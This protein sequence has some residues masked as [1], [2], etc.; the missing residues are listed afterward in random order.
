MEAAEF[1]FTASRGHVHVCL[2]YSHECFLPFSHH[3]PSLSFFWVGGTGEISARQVV[4]WQSCKLQ[5]TCNFKGFSVSQAF[6]VSAGPSINRSVWQRERTKYGY[7]NILH[8]FLLQYVFYTRVQN[9]YIFIK[10]WKHFKWISLPIWLTNISTSL[11]TCILSFFF[12]FCFLAIP[13][14]FSSHW[15]YSTCGHGQ[16][17]VNSQCVCVKD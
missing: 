1:F 12:F 16:V 14:Y 4:S 2:L 11:D 17:A 3:N 7:W 15:N 5:I 6:S 13:P 8:H 9:I 10:T